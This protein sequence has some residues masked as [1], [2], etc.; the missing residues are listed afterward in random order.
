[1][2]ESDN[3]NGRE[4]QAN[5]SDSSMPDEIIRREKTFQEQISLLSDT[6][7]SSD[8]NI[9]NLD[10]KYP[11]PAIRTFVRHASQTQLTGMLVDVLIAL[12]CKK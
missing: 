9:A 4:L 1:M 7:L 8:S 10:F 2:S 6:L 12:N 3:K 5:H 11:P